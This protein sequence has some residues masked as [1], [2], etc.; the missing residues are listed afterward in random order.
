MIRQ[1]ISATA[2][3]MALLVSQPA[4]ARHHLS[5]GAPVP[6]VS[7]AESGGPRRFEFVA[8]GRTF[9]SRDHAELYLLYRA[10]L[11]AQKRGIGSF[12]LL[13]LPGESPGTHPPKTDS[14]YASFSHWQPH[15]NYRLRGEGWQP[16]HPEWG[17][18]FWADKVDLKGVERFQLHAMVEMDVAMPSAESEAVFRTADVI[19][20]LRPRYRRSRS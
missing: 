15:W 1:V 6:E 18:R 11:F 3:A 12:A 16:W 8:D 14:G 17:D 19:A 13:Y 2:I 7:V 10:A 20:K 5:H 4:Q 9:T